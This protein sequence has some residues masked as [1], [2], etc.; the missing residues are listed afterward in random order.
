MKIIIITILVIFL[1]SKVTA[2]A[3]DISDEEINYAKNFIKEQ[4]T[5][6][7]WLKIDQKELDKEIRFQIVK[8]RMLIK[9]RNKKLVKCVSE[10]CLDM[11]LLEKILNCESKNE[12]DIKSKEVLRILK[13]I[14]F[15][16]VKKDCKEEKDINQMEMGILIE[17]EDKKIIGLKNIYIQDGKIK[18][19]K[20]INKNE[21]FIEIYSNKI[22]KITGLNVLKKIAKHEECDIFYGFGYT[23]FE[24]NKG[25]SKDNFKEL[26]KTNI[27]KIKRVYI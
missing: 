8:D 9:K 3:V 27:I 14:G 20:L 26:I 13:E 19:E 15:E 22:R 17:S 23:L 16:K 18:E 7:N 5:N 11:E 1:T 24:C 21:Y 6:K 10:K 4:M 2:N 25:L 12:K